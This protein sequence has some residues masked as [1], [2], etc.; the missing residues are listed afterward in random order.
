MILALPS[1]VSL[2][3]PLLSCVYY[4]QQAPA[5][6]AINDAFERQPS[7]ISVSRHECSMRPRYPSSAEGSTGGASVRPRIET[8]LTASCSGTLICV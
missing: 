4:F 7:L 3:R 5:M 6:Q 1:R 2:A 8:K